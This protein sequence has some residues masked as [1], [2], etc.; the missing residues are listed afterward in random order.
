MKQRGRKSAAALAVTAVDGRPTRLNPPSTLSEPE[1]RAFLDLVASVV[2]EHFVPCDLP[3][4]CAYVRAIALEER[5]AVQLRKTA[6]DSKWLAVW[7]KAQRA[8]VALSL[9]LRLSPQAR[10]R[11]AKPDPYAGGKL[12][13]WEI[14]ARRKPWDIVE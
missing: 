2:P 6:T 4:V 8:M 9:R 12:K 1:R 10:I 13:P 7:E 11:N 5:A 14:G 3:L